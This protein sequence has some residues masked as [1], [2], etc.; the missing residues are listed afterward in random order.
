M[1]GSRI[2]GIQFLMAIFLFNDFTI[3]KNIKYNPSNIKKNI[4][5]IYILL[6]VLIM[7]G[8][9]AI[10]SN[11][12][13]ISKLVEAMFSSSVIDNMIMNNQSDV[14]YST[15]S[16]I[17]MKEMGIINL[18]VMVKSFFAHISGVFLP[19]SIN[20]IY[21]NFP[22]FVV[23][24]SLNYGG[25]GGFFFGP[26]YIWF[27]ILGVGVFSIILGRII[28]KAYNN[29]CSNMMKFYVIIVLVTFFRWY[30]YTIYGIYKLPLYGLII[31]CFSNM[32]HNTMK[33][34]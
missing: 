2:V 29:E 13:S 20:G 14:I 30:P 12:F 6:G 22:K 27:G 3:I 9:G 21:G 16:L 24:N 32:L 7:K 4:Y 25:G 1:I 28:K 8:F 5:I 26:I 18:E 34:R 17:A 19:G 10:R 15:T 23:E 33:R 31:Y 11:G